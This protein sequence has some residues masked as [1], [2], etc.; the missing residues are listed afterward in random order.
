MS[1][2][3]RTQI[4]ILIL[5]PFIVGSLGEITGNLISNYFIN[6]NDEKEIVEEKDII[7]KPKP[8]Q[9]VNIENLFNDFLINCKKDEFSDN[10]IKQYFEKN[11][12]V[13]S[14]YEKTKTKTNDING[15]LNDIYTNK[16]LI[17]KINVKATKPININKNNKCTKIEIYEIRK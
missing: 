3:R 2:R 17:D 13:L 7:I 8:I 6:V 9:R 14:F 12:I 5:I 15:F 11:A 16:N 4:Y 1:N 10:E